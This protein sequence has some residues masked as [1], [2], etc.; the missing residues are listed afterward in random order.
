MEKTDRTSDHHLHTAATTSAK[1]NRSNT[2]QVSANG[3]NESVISPY[4]IRST[5][6]AVTQRAI[7][8]VV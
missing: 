2:R 8:T 3:F 6:H 7:E 4:Y 1:S 5:E